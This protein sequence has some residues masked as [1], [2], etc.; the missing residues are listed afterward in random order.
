[1]TRIEVRW[2]G[3]GTDVIENPPEAAWLLID[4]GGGAQTMWP[5]KQ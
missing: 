5:E 4:E 3:G 1:V 2:I